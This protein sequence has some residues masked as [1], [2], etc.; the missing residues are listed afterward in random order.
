M[1]SIDEVKDFGKN[2]FLFVANQLSIYREKVLS[3]ELLTN[4]DLYKFI[5]NK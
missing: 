3:C 1:S 5:K 4:E 2:A